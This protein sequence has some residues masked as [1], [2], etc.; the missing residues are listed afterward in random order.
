MAVTFTLGTFPDV[1]QFTMGATDVATKV[2]IPKG[3]KYASV[4]FVTNAGKIAMTGTD[5]AAINA[6][7]ID[8]PANT[9]VELRVRGCA[10]IYVAS[11]TGS[12]VCEVVVE[13]D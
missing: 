12:T 7:F 5:A 11:A 2:N 8:V 6:E 13:R 10:A 4:N 1:Q 3:S 9:C